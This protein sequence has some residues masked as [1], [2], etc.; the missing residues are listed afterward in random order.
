MSASVLFSL[1][2]EETW[3]A[4]TKSLVIVYMCYIAEITAK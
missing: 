3:K 1:G 2:A 4:A